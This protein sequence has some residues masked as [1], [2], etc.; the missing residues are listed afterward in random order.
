MWLLSSGDSDSGPEDLILFIFNQVN[1]KWVH[2]ASGYHI[3]ECNSRGVQSREALPATP[4]SSCF[5]LKG[6]VT[7]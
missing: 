5:F 3:E 2:V 1:F 7:F 4:R 6:T